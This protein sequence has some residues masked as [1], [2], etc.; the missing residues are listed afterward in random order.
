[1]SFLFKN[2]KA[3]SLRIYIEPSTDE[4]FL[5]SGDVLTV[6]PMYEAH[7]DFEFHIESDSIVVCIPRGQSAKLLL[8][9][10]R[11]ESFS[12]DFLW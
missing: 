9:G 2:T 11:L 3:T 5:S 7:S 12:E 4:V 6:I 10:D 8:N 1:M